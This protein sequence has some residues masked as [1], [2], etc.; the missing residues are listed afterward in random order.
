MS[1]ICAH[2]ERSHRHVTNL[3]VHVRVRWITKNDP[4]CTNSLRV[5]IILKMNS[6]QEKKKKKKN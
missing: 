6:I 4:A 5:F 2:G 1:L 3:V